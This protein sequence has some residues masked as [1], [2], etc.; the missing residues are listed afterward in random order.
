MF[1]SV[2]DDSLPFLTGRIAPLAPALLATLDVTRNLTKSTASGGA[3]RPIAKPSPPPNCSPGCPAPPLTVGNGNQPTFEPRPFLSFVLALNVEGAHW[4]M[5][6]I[7]A[8]PLPMVA[9]SPPAPSH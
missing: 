2:T 3:S 9:A 6:S 4:P 7:A 1:G 5:R 8:R